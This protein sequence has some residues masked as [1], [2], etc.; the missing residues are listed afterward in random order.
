MGFIS[1]FSAGWKKQQ[2]KERQRQKVV[3]AQI[4]KIS[5][6]SSFGGPIVAASVVVD[7]EAAARPSEVSLTID[8]NSRPSKGPPS[9]PSFEVIEMGEPA[10][11]KLDRHLSQ[12]PEILV[13][14]TMKKLDAETR[15]KL[16]KMRPRWFKLTWAQ[17]RDRIVDLGFELNI[18]EAIELRTSIRSAS[19]GALQAGGASTL[20]ADAE[21][22]SEEDE[23]SSTQNPIHPS[24][25]AE[26]LVRETM[27]GLSE[28]ERTRVLEGVDWGKMS[29]DERRDRI[30]EVGTGDLETRQQEDKEDWYRRNRGSAFR[31]QNE[32][33][34]EALQEALRLEARLEGREESFLKEAKRKEEK[35]KGGDHHS[36]SWYTQ[37]W[38]DGLK[39]K[40]VGD[41]EP[42]TDYGWPGRELTTEN[43]LVGFHAASLKELVDAL[44]KKEAMRV[45]TEDAKS[46]IRFTEEEWKAFGVKTPLQINHFVKAERTEEEGGGYTYFQITDEDNFREKSPIMF[47]CITISGS[48]ICLPCAPCYLLAQMECC[49]TLMARCSFFLLASLCCVAPPLYGFSMLTW[50][51]QNGGYPDPPPPS[52]PPSPAPPYVMPP[53]FMVPPPVSPPPLFPPGY[54]EGLICV[55]GRGG[56]LVCTE[57][58]L[59]WVLWRVVLSYVG[60]LGSFCM[61]SCWCMAVLPILVR[62]DDE[63]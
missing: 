46:Y 4:L 23:P 55:E 26:Q 57:E 59:G 41:K 13:R 7:E 24:L 42:T 45:E 11:P 18:P 60:S 2:Q 52:M 12:S 43:L 1:E 32:R 34:E 30:L 28:E 49:A 25:G 40:M 6:G 51:A 54:G 44:K 47:W 37:P 35:E 17:R 5:R 14:E 58:A 63:L 20:G 53:P 48:I 8:E 36:V 29:W 9:A 50:W 16:L 61:V 33:D 15:N 38:Q 39:W 27:P 3:K 10:P 62:G 22:S 56:R 21:S 19:A 31:R